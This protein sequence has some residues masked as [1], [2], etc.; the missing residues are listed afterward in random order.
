MIYLAHRC[1]LKWCVIKIILHTLQSRH[2]EGVARG[3]PCSLQMIMDC[4]A[5]LAMTAS[6]MFYQRVNEKY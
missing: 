4:F 1:K 2:C 5:S 6:E 3:N